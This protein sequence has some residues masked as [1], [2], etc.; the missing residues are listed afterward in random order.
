MLCYT[1]SGAAKSTSS[2]S[3]RSGNAPG[4]VGALSLCAHSLCAHSL[5]LYSFTLSLSLCS[6]TLCSR[7]V[8]PFVFALFI[9]VGFLDNI[10]FVDFLADSLLTVATDEW[11]A[12]LVVGF[13]AAILCQMVNNQPMTVLLST[14]LDRVSEREPAPKW[15]K[16]AYFALAI[17]A[18]LGGNGTPI[19]SLAVLMW[20]GILEKW[21][22]NMKYTVFSQKGL[23]VT[24][25]LVTL[26]VACTAIELVYWF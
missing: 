13:A 15:L 10:G 25:L 17:G 22:I 23:P 8:I 14:V 20:K 16:G 12:M 6:L 5:S 21:E 2:P 24:M 7:S 1:M 3:T 19:A 11:T 4:N 26:C 18:N 9:I